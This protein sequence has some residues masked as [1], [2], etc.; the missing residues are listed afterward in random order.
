M[1]APG[2]GTPLHPAL[3]CRRDWM[4]DFRVSMSPPPELQ[5][6]TY[7]LRNPPNPPIPLLFQH[8]LNRIVLVLQLLLSPPLLTRE[9]THGEPPETST[10]R[11]SNCTARLF[12]FPSPSAHLSWASFPSSRLG[13]VYF[14]THTPS[15][16]PFTCTGLSQGCFSPILSLI[17]GLVYPEHLK[18][19]SPNR[20]SKGQTTSHKSN[21]LGDHK[22]LRQ[23]HHR[24]AP[25]LL[26]SVQNFLLPSRHT[27]LS[28]PQSKPSNRTRN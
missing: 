20:S 18:R 1:L 19:P 27:R 5:H 23:D 8:T 4:L 26:T 22:R 9:R 6:S 28:L 17:V 7:D 25:A 3:M 10:R 13:S 2:L 24:L 12:S 11:A 16:V 14:Y 21:S 15:F